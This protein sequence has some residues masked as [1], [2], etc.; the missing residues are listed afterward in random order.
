GWVAAACH[1]GPADGPPARQ[2][3][4]EVRR[5]VRP[6][7]QAFLVAEDLA[8]CEG[9]AQLAVLQHVRRVARVSE[10]LLVDQEGFEENDAA[11]FHRALQRLEQG[12]L[13]IADVDRGVIARRWER[14]AF[15]VG[16]Y[17]TNRQTFCC[18]SGACAA[19]AGDGNVD[20]VDAV[21][22]ACQE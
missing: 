14:E 19:Q 7:D 3:S 2:A 9:A 1:I 11:G 13:Q 8:T 21:A 22:A 12:A 4:C 20:G 15:E 16:L 17:Q 18:S 6:L 5:T 10:L